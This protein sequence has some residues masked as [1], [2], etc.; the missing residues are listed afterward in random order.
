MIHNNSNEVPSIPDHFIQQEEI[1]SSLRI[2]K[3]ISEEE[4]ARVKKFT[5]DLMGLLKDIL[6][7]PKC[8]A[9]TMLKNYMD[10]MR[11]KRDFSKHPHLP[12]NGYKSKFYCKCIYETTKIIK[13]IT[14]LSRLVVSWQSQAMTECV[15]CHT[16]LKNTVWKVSCVIKHPA[17]NFSNTSA[18]PMFKGYSYTPLPLNNNK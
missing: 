6:D 7:D 1:T 12:E 8:P 18:I 17:L 15:S 16:N 11:L 13:D 14:G 2:A 5:E 4:N 3:K 9:S 10:I